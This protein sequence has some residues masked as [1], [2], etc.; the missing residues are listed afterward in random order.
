MPPV[1]NNKLFQAQLLNKQSVEQVLT[2][3]LTNFNLQIAEIDNRLQKVEDLTKK[4]VEETKSSVS[5]LIKSI[6][7]QK[8]LIKD[9]IISENEIKEEIQS[10]TKKLEKEL[11]TK[12]KIENIAI[13]DKITLFK[14]N[15]QKSLSN[16]VSFFGNIISGKHF[17]SNSN[18]ISKMFGIAKNSIKAFF[19]NTVGKLFDWVSE[20]GGVVFNVL[21]KLLNPITSVLKWLSSGAM[22][23]IENLYDKFT[24][25]AK[26]GWKVISSVWDFFS[27]KTKTIVEFFKDVFMELITS[28]IGF[29]LAVGAFVLAIN[30]V[31]KPAIKFIISVAEFIWDWLVKGVDKLF[32][33]SDSK[34]RQIFFHKQEKNIKDFFH[35]LWKNYLVPAYDKTIGALTGITSDKISSWFEPNRSNIKILE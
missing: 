25:L 30:Y 18:L 22:T 16:T 8:P 3:K 32:F 2:L 28:P 10:D 11:K 13:C 9:E 1:D 5:I 12:S 19:G 6:F 27:E 4:V 33:D 23:I 20:K 15:I 24:W 17:S 35:V 31:I 14:K 21:T 29:V 34:R 7:K 26:I